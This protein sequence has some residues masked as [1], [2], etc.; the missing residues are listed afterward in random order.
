MRRTFAALGFASVLAGTALAFTVLPPGASRAATKGEATF[1]IPAA[2]GYGVG[3]CLATGVSDC[4]KV[5]ATAWCEAQGYG[6]A[7]SF[8]PAAREDVTGTVQV[9]QVRAADL[10][11]AITC[12]D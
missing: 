10:P 4:G 2:D 11:I 12:M 9:A 1:L 3:D 8:G 5:V 6:Q 7:I